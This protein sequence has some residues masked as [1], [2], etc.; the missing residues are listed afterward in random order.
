MV[1]HEGCKVGAGSVIHSG[2]VLGADGFGF[3]PEKSAQGFK[4]T[5]VP[6]V[7]NVEIGANTCIDRATLGRTA[8]G[9][10]TKIDNLVQIGHNVRIGKS[11][12][13][14]GQ[15]GIAGSSK[16]GNQVVIGGNVGVRD[17]VE[18]VDGVRVAAKGG[19]IA[20]LTEP[21][22]YSGFPAVRAFT[23]RKQMRILAKLASNGKLFLQREQQEPDQN[24]SRKSLEN[25][26]NEKES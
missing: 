15:A 20:S 4:L 18:I 11:T 7:G 23:W 13:I 2:A 24:Q 3:F 6:Q 21:G 25:D 1:V 14:C 17:H 26:G 22:D 8:V 12:I 5:K 10:M 9:E 19:V 16:I